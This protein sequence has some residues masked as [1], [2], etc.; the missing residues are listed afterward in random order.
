MN[1]KKFK[2]PL[3]KRA[4][5][6]KRRSYDTLKSTELILFNA[7]IDTKRLKW[8]CLVY[9]MCLTCFSYG[10]TLVMNEFQGC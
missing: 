1:A 5:K 9:K 6:Y 8:H 3:H 7:S 4:L 10:V 2:C